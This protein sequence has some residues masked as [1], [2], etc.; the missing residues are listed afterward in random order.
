M[1]QQQKLDMPVQPTPTTQR[2]THA[3][4]GMYVCKMQKYVKSTILKNQFKKYKK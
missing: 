3:K 4:S 1:M 2:T